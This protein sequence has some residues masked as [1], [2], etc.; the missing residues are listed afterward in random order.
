MLK[1][2]IIS[3]IIRNALLKNLFVNSYT[4]FK[5]TVNLA[6]HVGEGF[7]PTDIQKTKEAKLMTQKLIILMTVK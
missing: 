4:L 5:K 3:I 6:R 7:A 2:V 1:I